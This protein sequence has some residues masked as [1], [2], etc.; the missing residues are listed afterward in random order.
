MKRTKAGRL[1]SF[2][3]SV[4]LVISAA[5]PVQ[6]ATARATTMKLEKMVGSVSVKTQSGSARKISEGMRL[7]N[8]N[9]VKTAKAS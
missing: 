2:L 1:L 4:L 9:T 5:V 8:G 7:Y 3:M 6:A